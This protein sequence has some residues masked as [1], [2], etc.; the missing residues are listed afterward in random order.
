MRT[1]GVEPHTAST[2]KRETAVRNVLHFFGSWSSYTYPAKPSISKGEGLRL[3]PS[4]RILDS[5]QASAC[6]KAFKHTFKLYTRLSGYY[7]A[8]IVD[9]RGPWRYCITSKS[10]PAQAPLSRET[11]DTDPTP[12]NNLSNTVREAMIAVERRQA[13][14]G[15]GVDI[16]IWSLKQ[17]FDEHHIATAGCMMQNGHPVFVWRKL[18]GGEWS[19]RFGLRPD[20]RYI[21]VA[22]CM[23]QDGHP[24]FVF[25]VDAKP[26][27]PKDGLKTCF[28]L[29]R[30][31]QSHQELQSAEPR[32]D[33]LVDEVIY[34]RDATHPENGAEDRWCSQCHNVLPAAD[35]RK[36][37]GIREVLSDDVCFATK[38]NGGDENLPSCNLGGATVVLKVDPK[39]IGN[40]A[41]G[42][43]A[44]RGKVSAQSIETIPRKSE[45]SDRGVKILAAAQNSMSTGSVPEQSS[46]YL[47]F[48]IAPQTSMPPKKKAVANSRSLYPLRQKGGMSSLAGHLDRGIYAHQCQYMT[49]ARKNPKSLANL[50]PRRSRA[51]A[52]TIDPEDIPD[53]S[54]VDATQASL[55]SDVEDE[56]SLY[57]D[58]DG[59]R[60][61]WEQ[62]SDGD[63][64][65][66]LEMVD[67][68]ELWN[69]K[70]LKA[71][72]LYDEMLTAAES[73]ENSCHFFDFDDP[74]DEDWLPPKER[75]QRDHN[76]AR[77]KE[78]GAEYARGPGI[79]NK[80]P[81][82]Q[83]RYK[84]AWA[85][86]T[87]L[88]DFVV[89]AKKQPKPHYIKSEPS[90]AT[91][92]FPHLDVR[93]RE[94]TPDPVTLEFLDCEIRNES[95]TPPPLAFE[96]D[97]LAQDEF[98]LDAFSN[99]PPDQTSAFTL[100]P[101]L[102]AS[103]GRLGS[104]PPAP[105]DPEGDDETGVES[106]E[107]ELNFAHIS[108]SDI[109]SWDVL[110]KQIDDDIK[111]GLKSKRLAQSQLN[112]LMILR[113]FAT[114]RLR[115]FGKM[116]A[117][118]RV[119]QQ[120]QNDIKGSAV[121][122][123]RRI[124]ALARHYQ[125]YEQ[126]PLE[127]RRGHRNARLLLKDEAVRNTAQA[128]LTS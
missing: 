60:Y 107:E 93:I 108:V 124:R 1:K 126:L 7:T 45:I 57:R 47:H 69:A 72:G 42:G 53:H 24:V 19:S 117:S 109:R 10:L 48:F 110:R 35:V 64:D 122:F 79:A 5:L 33:E 120:W 71:A 65:E 105:E 77:Q 38:G 28:V 125:Y 46:W 112:Q 14:V 99:A 78:R 70:K 66:E 87:D 90:P 44:Q 52:P 41:F 97:I 115:G 51:E 94:E 12:I 106:W 23:V 86:Q 54:A 61:E 88:D 95:V 83:R 31:W 100:Q 49:K 43:Y 91:E 85:S 68:Q 113:G 89:K 17:H 114:L 36:G 26:L 73:G 37:G 55:Q 20:K 15:D 39:S 3:A 98:W 30:G 40:D 9:I 21:A 104:P 4:I 102:L 13:I 58:P 11:N 84:K 22:N 8:D 123:A 34:F 76:A 29:V 32:I 119:A 118:K 96:D 82:T 75:I 101:E 50:Q 27:E 127:K 63:D 6:A 80:A 116:E 111:K 121:S 103:A 18:H 67:D 128:W 16:D 2:S 92:G 62:E 59:S 81:R 56:S 25:K 74:K